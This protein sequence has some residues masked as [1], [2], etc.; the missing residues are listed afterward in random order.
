MRT[1]VVL[2]LIGL[3][4]CGW[5]AGVFRA[6]ARFERTVP[7]TASGEFH[8]DNVNGKVRV[9][10]WD[11][12]EVRIEAEKSATD[13]AYLNEIRIEVR[14]EG[15]RVDVH[16][17]LPRGGWFW[18]GGHV[19]YL[20]HLPARATVDVRTVNGSVEVDGMDGSVRANTVN[21]SVRLTEAAGVLNATTVNGSIRA[22][23]RRAGSE[24]DHHFHT[25]NGSI[26][27]YLPLDAGG[28]VD[29]Q[30]V[31]GGMHTDFPLQ[32]TSKIGNR[33]IEGRLG[34][35][36]AVFRIRTVNGSVRILKAGTGKEV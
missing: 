25:T 15:D 10:P 17:R 21:G 2:G 19:E 3:A 36:R 1:L 35:G 20:I 4:G 27:L 13:E 7:L 6:R 9:E 26:T 18:G 24:G 12:A 16:T 14:G 22:D 33:R 29:A 11:R 23:Y 32:T 30:A 8:L 34:E 31:N 5:D 28:E